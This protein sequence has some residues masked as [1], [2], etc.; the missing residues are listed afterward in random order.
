MDPYEKRER[1]ERLYEALKTTMEQLS[2]LRGLSEELP[3]EMLPQLVRFHIFL[4]GK[5][6]YE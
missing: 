1:L 6:N 2:K 5:L 3:P 4:K